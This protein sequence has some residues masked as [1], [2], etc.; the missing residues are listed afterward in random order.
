M[1]SR[2]EGQNGHCLVLAHQVPDLSLSHLIEYFHHWKSFWKQVEMIGGY[3]QSIRQ[4]VC[5]QP[6]RL[7]VCAY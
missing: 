5:M 2:R 6:N 3:F 1:G 4:W 7:D